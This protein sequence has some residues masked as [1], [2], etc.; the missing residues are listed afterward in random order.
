[1]LLG[2]GL[3]VVVAVVASVLTITMPTTHLDLFLQGLMRLSVRSDL[4]CF[5]LCHCFYLLRCTVI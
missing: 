3:V 4:H 2:L 1:M 5:D